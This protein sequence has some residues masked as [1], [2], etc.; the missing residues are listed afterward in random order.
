MELKFI[1]NSFFKYLKRFNENEI[2]AL[3]NYLSLLTHDFNSDY[4]KFK[5]EFCN[6]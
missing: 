3:M 1:K 2:F 5:R 4:S 6:F